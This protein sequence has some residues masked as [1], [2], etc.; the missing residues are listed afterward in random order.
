M[1]EE[2]D[3]SPEPSSA[4]GFRTP[5]IARAEALARQLLRDQGMDEKQV[6]GALHA[7]AA[8]LRFIVLTI[9]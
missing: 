6:D 9:R 5:A 7:D 8:G 4:A 3:P 1:P 2:K